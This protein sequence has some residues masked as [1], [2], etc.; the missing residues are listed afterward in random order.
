ME[1]AFATSGKLLEACVLG[2]VKQKDTYGYDLTQKIAGTL[3]ISESTLYPVLR[4][5]SKEG[6]L[7]SYDQAF[8]GR[9]RKYYKITPE[10]ESQL[11]LYQNDWVAY[12]KNIRLLLKGGEF[13]EE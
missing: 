4:R 11:A 6:F 2:V 12:E 13:H 10:G 1:S 5:L 7:S 3:E 8:D 9:N